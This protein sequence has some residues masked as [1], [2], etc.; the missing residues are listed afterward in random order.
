MRSRLQRVIGSGALLCAL[1]AF[2]CSEDG[3]PI[4]PKDDLPAAPTGLQV[5][6]AADSS[7]TLRWSH[8]DTEVISYEVQ[9]RGGESAYQSRATITGPFLPLVTYQV[10]RLADRTSHTFRLRARNGNGPSDWSAEVSARTKTGAPRN[11]TAVGASLQAI[12]LS[13]EFFPPHPTRFELERRT[14]AGDW[15]R[16]SPN[17]P[18]TQRN[19]L[20]DGLAVFGEYD[21]RIRAIDQADTSAWSGL[22][23]AA[24]NGTGGGVDGALQRLRIAYALR[25]PDTLEGLFAADF[26]FEFSPS[27]LD[28]D[29]TTPLRWGRPS[30]EEA[31]RRML[32]S[33]DVSEVS[34]EF[35]A[36]PILEPDFDD[37]VPSTARK[38][39]LEDVH[40]RVVRAAKGSSVELEALDDRAEIFLRETDQSSGSGERIWEIVLWRDLADEGEKYTWGS[41]KRAFNPV[42]AVDADQQLANGPGIVANPEVEDSCGVVTRLADGPYDSAIAWAFDGAGPLE[43]GAFAQRFAGAAEVCA[44]V[45]D[46]T[47]VTATPSATLDLFVWQDELGAPG[48]VV[49]QRVDVQVTNI[50][51]W[52]EVSRHWVYLDR[53][54]VEGAW[55]AGFHG[56]WPG[57]SADFYIAASEI[58]SDTF[59]PFTRSADAWLPVSDIWPEVRALGIAVETRPCAD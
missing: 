16:I 45:L 37:P 54:C 38:V 50:A 57:E 32:T 22:A 3:D 7:V 29:P 51:A 25:D 47:A 56:N 2:G 53:C 9:S 59:P 33:R 5:T 58:A 43:I 31:T 42:V 26:S 14:A 17:P 20:D 11:L 19:Y 52:P 46:L 44:L 35:T 41:I 27:D 34:L 1:L 12:A 40:L 15:L 55:W 36:G 30:E 13:W 48:P 24:A 23:S 39:F 21:Y 18:P 28:R 8:A 6:A 49:C 10:I 4:D